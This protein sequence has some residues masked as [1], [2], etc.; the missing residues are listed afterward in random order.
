M[1]QDFVKCMDRNKPKN[2]K[3]SMTFCSVPM[4][5]DKKCFYERILVR[6]ST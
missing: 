5:E 4:Y 6:K 1:K 3:C 2:L